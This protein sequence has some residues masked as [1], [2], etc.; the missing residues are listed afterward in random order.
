VLGTQWR[1]TQRIPGTGR[2]EK[3]DTRTAKEPGSWGA[4]YWG[5]GNTERR[6]GSLQPAATLPSQTLET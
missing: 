1:R 2:D 5:S 6:D 3:R 4:G